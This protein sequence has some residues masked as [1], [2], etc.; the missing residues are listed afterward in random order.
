VIL[1]IFEQIFTPKNGWS[2]VGR[3][4]FLYIEYD[5]YAQKELMLLGAAGFTSCSVKNESIPG[6]NGW[7]RHRHRR[8][9]Y[10]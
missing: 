5:E 2:L 8:H 10:R 6:W 9:Q 7:E 4:I 1:L 3:G